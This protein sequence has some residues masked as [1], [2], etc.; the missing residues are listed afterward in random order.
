M[1]DLE[2]YDAAL[3]E[4]ALQIQGALSTRLRRS[5]GLSIGEAFSDELERIRAQRGY[6]K[7]KRE[8][9]SSKKQD[10]P[11]DE[12]D[13]T[14]IIHYQK[15]AEA[16][17]QAEATPI[18]LTARQITRALLRKF[19][20]DQKRDLEEWRNTQDSRDIDTLSRDNKV[21]FVHAL[22][23]E[24]Y[25]VWGHSTTQVNNQYL[26]ITETSGLEKARFIACLAPTVAASVLG[27]SS[28]D[29]YSKK[30]FYNTGVIIGGG[31]LLAAY[32]E[33]AKTY[34]WSLT[35]RRSKLD[36]KFYDEDRNYQNS[37]VQCDAPAMLREA[38]AGSA[39]KGHN[40]VCIYEPR[41][42]AVFMRVDDKLPPTTVA[43]NETQGRE[44]A[45][46]MGVPFVK[47]ARDGTLSSADDGSRLNVEDILACTRDFSK[48]ERLEMIKELPRIMSVEGHE[49]IAAKKLGRVRERIKEIEQE[50][51]GFSEPKGES[52]RAYSQERPHDIVQR[53]LKSAE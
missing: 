42:A 52:G 39:D 23:F 37:A 4:R 15:E 22:P 7:T 34:V 25:S 31:K 8:Q 29:G 24:W 16:L 9:L 20:A 46:E 50:R 14:D 44:I 51:D 11:G 26:D 38:M 32:P 53:L 21:L 1:Q 40:E 3:V 12:K 36:Q 17:R 43:K 45:R 35:D 2:R 28:E 27:A 18:A 19:Y 49:D 10:A 41:I 5:L 13:Y 48:E 30:T 33:D 6:A 47:I